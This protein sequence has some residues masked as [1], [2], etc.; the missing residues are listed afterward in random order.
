MW[1]LNP[2]GTKPVIF[3]ISI[4]APDGRN[5]ELFQL[6]FLTGC[7]NVLKSD[8]ES[9]ELVPFG[10]NL[11]NIGLQLS[12]C[13]SDYHLDQPWP[14]N[15]STHRTHFS[16]RTS[17]SKLF[18]L[19]N[20]HINPNFSLSSTSHTQLT[21]LTPWYVSPQGT[22]LG[23][24]RHHAIIPWDHDLDVLV[25]RSDKRKLT[26]AFGQMDKSTFSVVIYEE[27]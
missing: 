12:V 10:A 20:P 27:W 15:V 1:G 2:D 5:H 17:N 9:R 16:T 23:S 22:L 21:L 18:P 25:K 4:L 14:F 24:Y 3:Q 11:S 19:S 8:L 6:R 7:Q 26:T 13:P